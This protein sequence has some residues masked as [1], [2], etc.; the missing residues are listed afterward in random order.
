MITHGFVDWQGVGPI[1]SITHQLAAWFL[2]HCFAS[3]CAAEWS[4]ALARASPYGSGLGHHN[5]HNMHSPIARACVPTEQLD[6]ILSR[7]SV[8]LYVT[9]WL[10]VLKRWIKA[11]EQKGVGS[12]FT[13]LQTSEGCVD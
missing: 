4:K 13:D 9:V 6:S 3:D 1:N 2:D 5:R 11:P 7:R 8:L 10:S 12:N